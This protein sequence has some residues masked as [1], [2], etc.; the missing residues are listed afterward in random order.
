[1]A[2]PFITTAIHAARSAGALL[3]EN[4]GKDL[5]VNEMQ[6]HDIKLELDVRSQALIAGIL[7]DAHPGHAFFGEEGI[8]GDQDSPYQWIVD[9]IDGTVNYF[10]SI[11]HF[12]VSIGLRHQGKI[13]AG[14]IYDPLLDELFQVEKGKGAQL[15]GHPIHVSQRQLK[16]AVI[17]IG[18]SKDKASIDAGLERY[19][20]IAYSV[21]KTRVFGSAALALAYIACGRLDAYIEEQISIW[22][23]AAGWLLIEEAGG[24]VEVR[25]SPVKTGK[26]AII[27]ANR[28]IDLSDIPR[29]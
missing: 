3:K 28:T 25:V 8:E 16:D 19:K 23:I 18:F 14:V 4:F 15:N 2:E 9:P 29:D 10:Y 26:Q 20:Q 12:C 11:P 5:K 6:D 21:R 22:D 24:I 17:T 1:M 13:I 7:L 27:A